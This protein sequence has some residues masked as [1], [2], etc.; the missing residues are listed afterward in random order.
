MNGS[1]EEAIRLRVEE[2]L[3]VKDIVV[4]LGSSKSTVSGWVRDYPLTLEERAIRQSKNGRLKGG[5]NKHVEGDPSK[6]YLMRHGSSS[7][8]TGR[9]SEAAVIFRLAVL[10]LPVLANLFDG[11]KADLVVQVPSGDLVKIQVKS[12]KRQSHGRPLFNLICTSGM[13]KRNRY[14]DGDFDFLVGYDIFSDKAYVFSWNKVEKLTAVAAS[15][16]SEEK[17]GELL[18]F[19]RLAP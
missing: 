18:T 4:R 1:K 14:V 13:G 2:R 11:G 16:D 17:W 6:Y 12:A 10:G 3:S 5:W 9:V 8:N 7:A 19:I 15:E